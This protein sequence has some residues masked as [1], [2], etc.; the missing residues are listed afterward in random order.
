LPHPRLRGPPHVFSALRSLAERTRDAH[1]GGEIARRK[2]AALPG[3]ED[4]QPL[5]GRQR[6]PWGFFREGQTPAVFRSRGRRPL[7]LPLSHH[8]GCR[9]EALFCVY[10]LVLLAESLLERELR[11]AMEREG[12]KTI[13]LYPEG[14]PSRRPTARRLIDVFEPLQRHALED[15]E[16]QSLTLTPELSPLHRRLLRLLGVPAARYDD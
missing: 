4:Q 1:Q 8:F 6:L 10:F 16:G 11:Q 2:A 14:R 15:A 12:L 3:V 9:L 7:E 5:L 13:P